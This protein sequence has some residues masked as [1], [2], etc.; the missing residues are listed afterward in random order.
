[1]CES[2]PCPLIS[3]DSVNTFQRI[4]KDKGF[5]AVVRHDAM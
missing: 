5:C 2:A 3:N 1:M 4:R